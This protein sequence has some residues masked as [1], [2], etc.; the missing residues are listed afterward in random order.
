MLQLIK[1]TQSGFF[2]IEPTI[3]PPGSIQG[4]LDNPQTPPRHPPDTPKYGPFCIIWGSWQKRNQLVKMSEM[5]VCTL[6]PP[7]SIKSHSDRPQMPPKHLPDTIQTPQNIAHFDQSKQLWKREQADQKCSKFDC[8]Q[9]LAH[10]T[11][12]KIFRVT[13]TPRHL[14]DTQKKPQN[15]P[16]YGQS[17][18]NE[19]TSY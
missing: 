13:Q 2:S 16:F 19:R 12:Q 18:A 7:D 14:S 17:R 9:L 15:G 11:S 8:Y 3:Y 10:H 5:G 4:Q 6:Y 1:M